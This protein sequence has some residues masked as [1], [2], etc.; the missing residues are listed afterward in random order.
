MTGVGRHLQ[1]NRLPRGP[2]GTENRKPEYEHLLICA[3]SGNLT[4]WTANEVHGQCWRTD[5]LDLCIGFLHLTSNC[6][7][8]TTYL[9]WISLSKAQAK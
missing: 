6:I 2:H 1:G 4:T 9:I 3:F 7:Q 8:L 5:S